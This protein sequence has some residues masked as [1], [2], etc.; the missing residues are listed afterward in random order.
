MKTILAALA[1]TALLATA[2]LA[3]APSVKSIAVEGTEIVVTLGD[4]RSLRSKD[5][6]GAVLDVRFD[7]QPTKIRIAAVEPDPDDKSKTVWL[8]TFEGQNPQGVWGNLC[9][10]G[11]DGRRM[12]FP[13][14]TGAGGLDFT[15]TSGAVGKCVR[16]GYRPWADGPDGTSLA[17]RHAA[18]VR[19][20]RGDYG[21]DGQP[22]TK[23]GMSIDMYDQLGVQ[24]PDN[25]P[26]QAFEAGWT[27]E[28]A[29]CVHHVRV[30]EN[31]TLEALE[32]KYPRL[33]GRTGAACTEDFAK[34]NGAVVFN[35][36]RP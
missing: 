35:R 8:H 29:V 36:S 20:V 4:G 14:K 16:F 22:W 30:K 31:T 32:A 21:G 26:T 6:V 24:T 23:D 2:S 5:L 15:C 19:M 12:G 27:P 18:C 3:Q 34:A 25:S 1:G 17:P 33:K 7:G 9:G 10:E 11:P 28:G 13:L